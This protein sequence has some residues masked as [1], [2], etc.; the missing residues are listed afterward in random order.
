[1]VSPD[2]VEKIAGLAD[3]RLAKERLG[4]FT[5]EFNAILE[6]FDVLDGVRE[7]AGE[8]GGAFNVMREDE[9]G[10]CLSQEEVLSLA[11]ESE[12]GFVRAPRVME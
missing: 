2:D 10:T 7:E 11:P 5:R 8:E 9:A 3:I 4:G 6:Y 12:E 1:M